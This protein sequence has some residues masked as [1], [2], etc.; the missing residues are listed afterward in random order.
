MRLTQALN[1]PGR[2]ASCTPF[3]EVMTSPTA[4]GELTKALFT[5]TRTPVP[6]SV[7]SI[8]TPSE[9]LGMVSVIDSTSDMSCVSNS[10]V[11]IAGRR[12]R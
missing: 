11:S 5:T 4:S 12:L 3:T 1:P 10:I 9:P 7:G 6:S 2:V 8:S